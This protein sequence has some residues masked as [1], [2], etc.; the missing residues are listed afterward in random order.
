MAENDRVMEPPRE[1]TKSPGA[2]LDAFA[3][4]M[5]PKGEVQGCTESNPFAL[6]FLSPRHAPWMARVYPPAPTSHGFA[7]QISRPD[8]FAPA[9]AGS[10]A[11][12]QEPAPA[13]EGVL[14]RQLPHRKLLILNPEQDRVRQFAI[15]IHLGVI[16]GA[17]ESMLVLNLQFA[18]VELAALETFAG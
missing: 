1:F 2:I 3:A 14:S 13:G 4:R 5:R 11:D 17:G 9:G 18:N 12:L 16:D 10:Y 8:H 7:S 15:D 6:T